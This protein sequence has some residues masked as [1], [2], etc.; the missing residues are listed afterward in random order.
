MA[1]ITLT[2]SNLQIPSS[3]LNTSFPY[4]CFLAFHPAQFIFNKTRAA[5]S[6]TVLTLSFS[7]DV[8]LRQICSS[9]C[10]ICSSFVGRCR[11]ALRLRNMVDEQDNKTDG[12]TFCNLHTVYLEIFFLRT[13]N[14]SSESHQR[15][16]T[17]N[18]QKSSATRHNKSSE[19]HQR[20]VTINLQ[21]VI[22]D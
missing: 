8:L 17:I 6:W 20:L 14:K 3:V 21:K 15:L 10:A 22:S 5:I 9:C 12:H 18:L 11:T 16:V 19:S 4:I 2:C 7:I 1:Y 13:H